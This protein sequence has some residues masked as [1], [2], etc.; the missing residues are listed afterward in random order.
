MNRRHLLA[1]AAA[2]GALSAFGVSPVPAQAR[3]NFTFW[4]AM[5]GPLGDEVKK[6][7]DAFSA[8]QGEFSVEPVFKGSYSETMTAAVAAFRAGKAPNLVQVFEVG[9]G[10]MLGAGAAVKQTWQLSQDTGLSIDPNSYMAAVRGYYSLPDGRMASMPFNSSTPVLWINKDIFEKAGLDPERAPATWQE[11]VSAAKTI[12]AKGAAKVPMTTAWPTWVMMEC[13]GAIH[14]LPYATKANGFEGLDADL[15][16]NTAPYVKQM[17][18]LL[19]M[20]KDGTFTYG[21]RGASGDQIFPAGETAMS[22][23]SSGSRSAFV[24]DARFRFSAALLPF[25]P[26]VKTTPN[27]SIIGGAS[28]WAMTAPS[29]PV[30][31]YKAVAAFLKF[32]AQPENDAKWSQATG[33][34]PVTL[35]GAGVSLAQGYYSRNPGADIAIQQLNRGTVTENSK[36]LRLGRL[37]EIRNI[38]EEE[39]EAALQGR[40]NAQAALDSAVARGNKVL[41]EFE[42]SMRS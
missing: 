27:N 37:P 4:H 13:Y 28:L 5:A 32:I 36:G 8:S 9:T 38:I 25:D 19:D 24:R 26:E 42:R 16:F 14:N 40:Q 11:V 10:S 35:A 41:R 31:E 29:R 6:V 21:G 30:A 1:G 15:V 20:A 34:V 22:F 23:N 3:T 12:K 33:Y 2:M 39:F 18:R 7:C 17:Q